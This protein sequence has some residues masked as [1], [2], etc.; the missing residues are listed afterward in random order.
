MFKWIRNKLY[1]DRTEIPDKKDIRYLEYIVEQFLHSKKRLDMITGERYYLGQHDIL[2]AKREVIEEGGR[3]ETV[4]NLPNN[5]RVDNQYEKLVDQ[6][7][8]YLLGKPI[9]FKTENTLYQEQLEKIFDL[10]FQKIFK[11]V[12]ED[13]MN[14]GI[15]WLYPY[16]NENG[17]FLFKRFEPC[18]I[19]PIWKDEGH[20]ELD[21][22]IRIYTVQRWT[23]SMLE[24]VEVV[25]VYSLAGI[26]RYK[27]SWGSL[28]YE[29]HYNYFNI[30]EE[31]F[32]WDRLPI[33]PFKYNLL[34]K[35]LILRVKNLQDGINKAVSNF[36]NNLDENPRNCILILKNYDG[37][38]L[39]EFRKNLSTFGAVKVRDDG[40]VEKL[41]VELNS[42]NYKDIIKIFKDA[43]IENG[44]GFNAK[45]DRLGNNPN[46][47]N[48]QSMYAD[49]D[50]DASGMEVEFRSGL[51][52]LLNFVNAHISHLGLGDF[53]NENIEIIF[54]KDILVN[55][56]Q[57]IDNCAKSIGIISDETIISMHPWVKNT[58]EEIKKIKKQKEEETEEYNGAFKN[59]NGSGGIDEEE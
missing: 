22:A 11:N 58:L 53:E 51:N 42:E 59:R 20:T 55:E 21:F 33:I 50:L 47:M 23:G 27:Y 43:L 31:Q 48:I 57:T 3:L 46:E 36:E 26:D 2:W 7:V 32:N 41:T 16:Y 5:K 24:D 18:Q 54:N 29:G 40:G 15:A 35:P 17:D 38:N 9:T 6:K 12:A 34:E 45:D 44:R 19:L 28:K 14:G 56:S 30:G 10:E 52:K 25:D 4:D 37:Q 8:N 49:I 13:A 1:R 39:G